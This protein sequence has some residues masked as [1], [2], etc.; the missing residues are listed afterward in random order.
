MSV[1]LGSLIFQV[2]KSSGL[3]SRSDFTNAW[4][5]QLQ[6]KEPVSASRTLHG[7][8]A[9]QQVQW[10]AGNVPKGSGIKSGLISASTATSSGLLRA[11]DCGSQAARWPG[12]HP[13]VVVGWHLL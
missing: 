10:A 11:G 12:G 5:W 13:L 3:F 4:P 2:T 8:K 6:W 7:R 1:L 9:A